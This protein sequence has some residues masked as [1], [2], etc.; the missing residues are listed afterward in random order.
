M[1]FP[2]PLANGRSG[3][4]DQSAHQSSLKLGRRLSSTAALQPGRKDLTCIFMQRV[5][6]FRVQK[7]TGPRV[8]E[9]GVSSDTVPFDNNVFVNCPFDASYCALVRPLLFTIIYL[10]LK[11]RIA[12]ERSDS[13]EPRIEK[14]FEL[15][16]ESRYGIHDLSRIEASTVGEIFRLNM[17]F[18]LGIDVGCRRF[19][20]G[21][22]RRRRP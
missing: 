14:I 8:Q 7:A 20:R 15:I 13:G 3:V 11:P 22:Q 6:L 9:I 18:E 5:E 1:W 21:R 19:G 10:K 2:R 16:R 12:L 4:P 17:P